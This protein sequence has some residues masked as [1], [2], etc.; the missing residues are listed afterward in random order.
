MEVQFFVYGVP[1]GE[2]IWGR[3]NDANYFSTFY[4]SCSDKQKYLIQVR[5]ADGKN[6]C[7]YNYLV[8]HNII[9]YDGRAGAYI[10]LTIRVE[11]TYCKDFFG[12]YRILDFV[13]N[14]YAIGNLLKSEGDR[15]RFRIPN[16]Q[17]GNSDIQAMEDETF[18][19]FQSAFSTDDFI[20]LNGFTIAGG[21]IQ[22]INL[23]DCTSDNVVAIVKNYGK[24]AISPYYPRS[25]EHEMQQQLNLQ[26]QTVQQQY[27]FKLKQQ[28]DIFQQERNNSETKANLQ[29]S[30]ILQC[31]EEMKK[32]DGKIEEL[33]RENEKYKKEIQT[34]GQSRKIEKLI[35]PIK[36]PIQELAKSMQQIAP[37]VRYEANEPRRKQNNHLGNLKNVALLLTFVN[38]L[39]IIGIL[40][41]VGFSQ[42]KQNKNDMDSIH[43][44][45]IKEAREKVEAELENFNINGVKLDISEYESGK[46]EKN[47]E[48][49]VKAI[50]SGEYAIGWIVEG[51]EKVDTEDK[52]Q[53]KII[54]KENMVKIVYIVGGK[55]KRREIEA[56]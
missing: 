19:L 54:P 20:S 15:Q 55:C 44:K 32:K 13:Y 43:E 38:T 48:Y 3:V 51:A 18:R 30:Q 39:L 4:T 34:M 17:E 5:Q 23:Y 29:K 12:I 33:K 35:E 14:H 27:E 16:F 49:S 6:Y 26:V 56:K 11:E 46:L 22:S 10:G 45:A 7:Y 41:I 42:Y 28:Q 47:K 2:S 24:V 9:G 8:Y 37:E 21:N 53:I 36:I 52:N 40:F 25:K 50:N 31:Q 1:H